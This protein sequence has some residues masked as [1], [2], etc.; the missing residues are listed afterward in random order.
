MYPKSMFKNKSKKNIEYPSKPKFY[1]I[2]VG[3]KG[4]YITWTFLHD[5]KLDGVARGYVQVGFCSML[6]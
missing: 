6:H 3:C 2:T 5:E 1:Y 4:V